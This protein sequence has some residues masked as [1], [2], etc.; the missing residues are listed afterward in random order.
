MM[1][2][3]T[4]SKRNEPPMLAKGFRECQCAMVCARVSVLIDHADPCRIHVR[5]V[6]SQ[7]FKKKKKKLWKFHQIRSLSRLLRGITRISVNGESHKR[8][9]SGLPGDPS[10]SIDGGNGGLGGEAPPKLGFL[11]NEPLGP[12]PHAR[13][14]Q[15]QSAHLLHLVH[16]HQFVS[17]HGGDYCS[18]NEHP[19]QGLA[20]ETLFGVIAKPGRGRESSLAINFVPDAQMDAIAITLGPD[21]AGRGARPGRGLGARPAG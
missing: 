21:E 1:T 6:S 3:R 13:R 16:A 12:N 20:D 4:V 9:K 18:R 15:G 8:G 19:L 5:L 17:R 11:K 2:P 7:I 14:N 10:A